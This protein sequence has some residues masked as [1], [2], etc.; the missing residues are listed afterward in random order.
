MKFCSASTNADPRCYDN[1]TSAP[2]LHNDSGYSMYG[3]NPENQGLLTT[4]SNTCN[5]VDRHREWGRYSAFNVHNQ[6]ETYH[7]IQEPCLQR[8]LV[9]PTDHHTDGYWLSH[10]RHHG[11][12]Q[13]YTRGL[14]ANRFHYSQ[15]AYG[16]DYLLPPG[17]YLLS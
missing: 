7:R 15:D 1:G 6:V 3:V 17:K 16:R 14:E 8:T 10:P 13:M 5:S 4:S 9:A 2:S 11:E 12:V